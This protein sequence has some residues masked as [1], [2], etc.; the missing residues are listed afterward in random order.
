[1]MGPV[2]DTLFV[3]TC[4][5]LVIL[6][7]GDW[8]NP[9]LDGITLTAN[10]FETALPGYG[11]GMLVFI[12]VLLGGS[13]VLSMWYYGA[14][15]MGFLFGADKQRYYVWIYTVLV[16]VG[17]VVSLNVVIGLIDG[18]YAVMAIP[19]MTSAIALSPKVRAAA[20]EYFASLRNL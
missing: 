6:I 17:A 9:A 3:C 16:V 10:A 14:K 15:C 20:N 4:T 13:T 19:T 5:A 2:I 18:M 8:R 11:A 1:M 7:A 12:A